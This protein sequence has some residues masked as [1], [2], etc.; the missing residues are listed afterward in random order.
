MPVVLFCRKTEAPTE[1]GWYYGS[2]H[3]HPMLRHL[4]KPIEPILCLNQGDRIL[5]FYAAEYRETYYF[6]WFGPVPTC[7]EMT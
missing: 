2:F 5:A 4:S 7:Q 1:P 6:N 3:S